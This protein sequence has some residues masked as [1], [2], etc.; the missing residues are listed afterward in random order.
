MVNMKCQASYQSRNTSSSFLSLGQLSLFSIDN[1]IFLKLLQSLSE[2]TVGKKG[3]SSF[4]LAK[5]LKSNPEKNLCFFAFLAPYLA[6]G[7]FLSNLVISWAV[8]LSNLHGNLTSLFIIALNTSIGVAPSN[9]ILP[10]KVS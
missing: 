8:F 3:G 4:F 6:L 9:G 7:S 5:D 2:S 10:V 1:S